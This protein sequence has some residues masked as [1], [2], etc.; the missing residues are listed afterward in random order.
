[1]GQTAIKLNNNWKR[2]FFSIR[3]MEITK[4]ILFDYI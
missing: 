4:T 3:I 2:K 1:M